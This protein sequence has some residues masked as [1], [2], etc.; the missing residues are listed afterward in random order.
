MLGTGIAE[1]FDLFSDFDEESTSDTS[2]IYQHIRR[3]FVISQAKHQSPRKR[4]YTPKFVSVSGPEEA[5][6]N[7]GLRPAMEDAHIC[8]KLETSAT[9]CVKRD[10]NNDVLFFAILDGHGGDESS[11]WLS[12]NLVPILTNHLNTERSVENSLNKAFQE[13]NELLLLQNFKSGSTCVSILIEEATGV[14]WMANV[15]DSRC[16]LSNGWA[17]EDHRPS[18]LD[19]AERVRLAGGCIVNNRVLGLLSVTRAFGDKLL[20]PSVICTPEIRKIQLNPNDH[21]FCIL[22]C[23]GLWDVMSNDLAITLC[24]DGFT[25]ANSEA[26][27]WSLVAAAIQH[28]K[29]LDNVSVIVLKFNY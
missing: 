17:T 18:R 11:N 6:S 12:V 3:R 15:G 10:N 27:G 22:A 26:I 5:A 4:R 29:S 7:Q 14:A 9:A 16:V 13:A 24:S 25:I 21:Q 2:E 28:C 20:K 1:P 23:D 19:E 8:T